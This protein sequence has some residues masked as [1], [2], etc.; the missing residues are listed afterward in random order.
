MFYTVLLNLS[1][2]VDPFFIVP[3]I[4]RVGFT[5]CFGSQALITVVVC[6]PVLAVLH[7][8]GQRIRKGCGE[9]DWVDPGAVVP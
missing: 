3:W 5:W 2:F 8:F 6:I 9:P 1:A 4:D 7:R